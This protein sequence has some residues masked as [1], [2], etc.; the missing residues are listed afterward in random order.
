MD[1]YAFMDIWKASEPSLKKADQSTFGSGIAVISLLMDA[2]LF[3]IFI[4]LK[5]EL[6]MT[7]ITK[8]KNVIWVTF[9]VLT[10]SYVF[11]C[12]N[13][14]HISETSQVWFMKIVIK[15][16]MDRFATVFYYKHL[17]IYVSYSKFVNAFAKAL[18]TPPE[19]NVTLYS[20]CIR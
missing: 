5:L 15:M 12:D 20:M 10:F 6:D 13:V 14:L 2:K 18:T 4:F 19:L 16:I 8:H 17:N 3:S 7:S 1:T 11:G 9:S